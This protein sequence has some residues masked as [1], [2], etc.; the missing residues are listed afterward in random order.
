MRQPRARKLSTSVAVVGSAAQSIA[1]RGRRTLYDMK[2]C[3]DEASALAESLDSSC[4]WVVYRALKA[5]G[6]CCTSGG[7]S[8]W[9]LSRRPSCLPAG[10]VSAW[11][12]GS[13]AGWLEPCR[14]AAIKPTHSTYNHTD[15]TDVLVGSSSVRPGIHLCSLL[16][17][18]VC[19][20]T[21][22]PARFWETQLPDSGH[23]VTSAASSSWC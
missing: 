6:S 11:G 1:A 17:R 9:T 12:G 20:V 13:A 3:W 7:E 10:K 16:I 21:C 14:V 18:A 22:R 23:P 15:L 4:T 2:Y 8:G 19:R 5:S